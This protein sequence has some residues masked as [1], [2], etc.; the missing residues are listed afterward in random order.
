MIN[1][2]SLWARQIILAVLI[3]I[4]L[5]MILIKNSKNTKYIKTVI[6]IYIMYVII[7]PGLKLFNKG[8]IDFSNIDYNKY[9]LEKD[10][11]KKMD[12]NI[13]NID[14]KNTYELNLKQ[15][16]EE[17]LRTRGYIVSNVKLNLNMNTKSDSYG[18]I[19]KME[20][21]LSKKNNIDD[22]P[23]EKNNKISIDKINIKNSEK[24]SDEYIE[25]EDELKEFFKQEY[26]VD[27]I[28][29]K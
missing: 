2:I 13:E 22:N 18:E 15:D 26:G 27:N 24:N 17:K 16:I 28:I 11:Y 8:E 7:T 21:K 4:I 29:I 6:G 19:T 9:F 3:A 25:D 5:E 20:I 14:L 12:V 23:E 1:Y 10:T